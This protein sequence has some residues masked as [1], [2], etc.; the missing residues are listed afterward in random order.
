MGEFASRAR[1]TEGRHE[2]GLLLLSAPHPSMERL[3]TVCGAEPCMLRGKKYVLQAWAD[4]MARPLNQNTELRRMET[5]TVDP[6]TAAS[7]ALIHACWWTDL[8]L[9]M[10]IIQDLRELVD[11]N[12]LI[13]NRNILEWTLNPTRWN[14]DK[15][16][17]DDTGNICRYLIVCYGSR[18][19][20][21]RFDSYVLR[22]CIEK[23]Y[24]DVVAHIA[25]TY[26][27]ILADD[28]SGV[29]KCLVK[30]GQDEA[31]QLYLGSH[32]YQLIQVLTDILRHAAYYASTQMF[33]SILNTF[34]SVIMSLTAN[35]IFGLLCETSVPDR[36]D[37]IRAVLDAWAAQLDI[38]TIEA[39]LVNCWMRRIQDKADST[40]AQVIIE[41]CID[42]LRNRGIKIAMALCLPVRE[43]LL[44][45][46]FA[47]RE[48]LLPTPFAVHEALLPT[49]FAVH[50]ALC[51]LRLPSNLELFDTILERNLD[52]INANP[53]LLR[54]TL[55]ECCWLCDIDILAHILNKCNGYLQ[56]SRSYIYSNALVF[57]CDKGDLEAVTL[58]FEMGESCE[59]LIDSIPKVFVSA[60]QRGDVELAELL[61]RFAGDT[62]TEATYQK[63]FS[64]ACYD[65]HTDVIVSLATHQRD[66]L[67]IRCDAD[68]KF[69]F[70]YMTPEV[71][72]LLNSIYDTTLD[73]NSGGN[74]NLTIK[75]SPGGHAIT[76]G[77][78][79]DVIYSLYR[80]TPVKNPI[81]LG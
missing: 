26:D 29:F 1:I 33:A 52:H 48:A 16:R 32:R 15:T 19:N 22:T 64:F 55:L 68:Y 36:D 21:N 54:H 65:R 8:E 66:H 41:R 62:V 24:A 3:L 71:I 43:A 50:E 57:W 13:D 60:C 5:K 39:G 23:D 37:R 76:Y 59:A 49:P 18:L 79:K 40:I 77:R 53:S 27:P 7:H 51:P 73:P 81:I 34:K 9:V 42:R 46:P 25:T 4:C 75:A 67:D 80:T 30:G 74:Q 63:A 10:W 14:I 72:N 61:I 28:A 38:G 45:T 44:P 47:V 58:L 2:V 78:F 70:K 11:I 6:R 56:P 20:A 31:A 17:D 35:S 69:D 12:A